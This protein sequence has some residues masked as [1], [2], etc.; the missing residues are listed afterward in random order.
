MAPWQG[1]ENK[2]PDFMA[3]G[4]SYDQILLVLTMIQV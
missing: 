4:V 1:Q 2:G 3:G